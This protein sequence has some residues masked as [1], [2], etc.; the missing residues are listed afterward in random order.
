MTTNDK[1]SSGDYYGELYKG[2][3]TGIDIRVV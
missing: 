2:R 1:G 3:R